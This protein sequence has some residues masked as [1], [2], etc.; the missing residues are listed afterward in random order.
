MDIFEF[1]DHCRFLI[2]EN[3]K[4]RNY[5]EAARIAKILAD[6]LIEQAEKWVER[7]L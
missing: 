2:S 3:V 1:I 6:A 7:G 5:A 4:G